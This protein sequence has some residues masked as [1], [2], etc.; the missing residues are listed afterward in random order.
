M[1][2]V[3]S[4]FPFMI[5]LLLG[6]LVAGPLDLETAS[7]AV[8]TAPR[9]GATRTRVVAIRAP[10]SRRTTRYFTS[11]AMTGTRYKGPCGSPPDHA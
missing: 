6:L 2:R 3:A 11:L 10:E 8:S 4:V 5:V 7:P 1:R 9:P